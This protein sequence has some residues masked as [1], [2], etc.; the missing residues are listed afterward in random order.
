MHTNRL[1][2]EGIDDLDVRLPAKCNPLPLRHDGSIHLVQ[3]NRSVSHPNE[4]GTKPLWSS[5]GHSE[6]VPRIG[7]QAKQRL[8]AGVKP[9]AC[10]SQPVR[11]ND[12][13]KAGP[14]EQHRDR[15]Q[16]I[17]FRLD[18]AKFSQLK[19][20][21]RSCLIPLGN[22]RPI[23]RRAVTRLSRSIALIGSVDQEQFLQI[24]G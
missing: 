18:L 22:L 4:L 5:L 1:S 15:P 16:M 2:R 17:V 11:L 12:V 13:C 10:F 3:L 24:I 14:M 8:V 23:D 9:S 19:H 6:A 7:P 21:M 20:S